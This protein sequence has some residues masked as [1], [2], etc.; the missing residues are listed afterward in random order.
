MTFTYVDLITYESFY[1]IFMNNCTI[2]YSDV[3]L[4]KHMCGKKPGTKVDKIILNPKDGSWTIPKSKTP[5]P[6]KPLV[7]EFKGVHTRFEDGEVTG[8]NPIGLDKA[9][10]SDNPIGLDDNLVYV[11]NE[12]KSSTFKIY[13]GRRRVTR[14][15]YDV[16][17]EFSK[18]IHDL[19]C[20][21]T[22]TIVINNSTDLI[23]VAGIDLESH[24]ILKLRYKLPS[25][26]YSIVR[27][28]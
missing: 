1:I 26:N 13:E 19:G 18:Y 20:G 12:I 14:I 3:T 15:S 17:E 7:V 22:D 5:V 23:R 16:I 24:F 25:G 2:E 9:T 27:V 6:K 10:V 8:D 11:P 4:L 21:S 28:Y